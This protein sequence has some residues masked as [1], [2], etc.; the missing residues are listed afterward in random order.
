MENQ[1]LIRKALNIVCY[2][3]RVLFLHGVFIIFN[4][5]LCNLAL[6]LPYSSLLFPCQDTNYRQADSIIL[7]Y[8]VALRLFIEKITSH[9]STAVGNMS[10]LK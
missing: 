3:V 7:A 6:C 2:I 8:S 4:Y 10:C 9:L 5:S 1:S